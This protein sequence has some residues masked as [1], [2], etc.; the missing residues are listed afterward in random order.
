MAS[1]RAS[2]GSLGREAV[3]VIGAMLGT[4]GA[5]SL[6]GDVLLMSPRDIG[7]GGLALVELPMAREAPFLAGVD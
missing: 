5:T 3:Q 1:V 7:G 6:V 2:T 4:G